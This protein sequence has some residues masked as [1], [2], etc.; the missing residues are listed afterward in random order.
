M[1]TI[2]GVEIVENPHLTPVPVLKLRPEVP[3]SDAFRTEMD[4]WLLDMFGEKTVWFLLN[5]KI[6]AHPTAIARL[7]QT[8]APFTFSS[9]APLRNLNE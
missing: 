6:Y 4:S 7:K 1:T 8:T 9:W 3:V 2:W 5:G